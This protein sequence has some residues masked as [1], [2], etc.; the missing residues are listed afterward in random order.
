MTPLAASIAASDSIIA[1]RTDSSASR[2]CGGTGAVAAISFGPPQR[3]RAARAGGAPP[4]L[5][6]PSACREL[7]LGPAC[8][9]VEKRSSAALEVA[10]CRHVRTYVRIASGRRVEESDRSER[11]LPL[12]FHSRGHGCGEFRPPS[13][14]QPVDNRAEVPCGVPRRAVD[15][16]CRNWYVWAP[17]PKLA[18]P[19]EGGGFPP[20]RVGLKAP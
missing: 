18:L 11:E 16:K 2:F 10:F 12:E 6:G 15:E 1:P 7:G 20:T 4:V 14:P 19:L 8:N 17:C 3:R 13:S 9:A 5:P